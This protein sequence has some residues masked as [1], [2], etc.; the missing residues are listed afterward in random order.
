MRVLRHSALLLA[1]AGI[2]YAGGACALSTDSTSSQC[3]SQED[4]LS[5]GSEFADTTCSE[6]R[7]CVNLKVERRGCVTNQECLA[8]NGGA[9]FT[10]RKEDGKCV[11]L[12]TAECPYLYADGDD[13]ADD[14]TVFVGNITTIDANSTLTEQ[15]VQLARFEIKRAGGLVPQKPD[16]PRR[17]L[18]VVSCNAEPNTVGVGTAL[19][20]QRALDHLHKTLRV[21]MRLGPLTTGPT[22]AGAQASIDRKSLMLTR[23]GSPDLTRLADQDLIFRVGFSDT[24]TTVI[25]PRL[26]DEQIVPAMIDA[27]MLGASEQPRIA[28]VISAEQSRTGEALTAAGFNRP[29]Q[30]FN[31]GAATDFVNNP[32]PQAVITKT[33]IDVRN[34]QP[35]L[36][37]YALPPSGVGLAF[38]PINAGWPS[39]VP[40]PFQISVVPTFAG[41]PLVTAVNA[42]ADDTVRS[43]LYALFPAAPDFVPADAE[44]LQANL[45]LRFP[46]LTANTAPQFVRN[47]YDA[48]YI[49]AYAAAAIGDQPLTGVNLTAGVRRVADASGGVPHN[50]GPQNYSAIIATL[51]TGQNVSYRGVDGPYSFDANGERPAHTEVHCVRRSPPGLVFSGYRRDAA[52]GQLTGEINC[53]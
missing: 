53:P 50:W 45:K 46:E 18:V 30:T 40:R 5:R 8:Q 24:A 38:T 11:G 43:R 2:G 20:V 41:A 29:F 35:H 44:L 16:G 10:C 26:V 48:M 27:G 39:S 9:P 13:L 23:N 17:P 3:R 22:A 28:L 36:I 37:I 34:Y 32:N 33:V 51:G 7:I 52:T 21:P 12:L 4:C 42:I 6:E 49:F 19:E 25:I 31:Y 14:N 47:A 15:A 1:I